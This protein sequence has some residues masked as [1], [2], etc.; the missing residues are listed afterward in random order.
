M[1]REDR[2][3]IPRTVRIAAVLFLAYGAW[4]VWRAAAVQIATHWVDGGDFPRAVIRLAGMSLVSYGLL[5]Q[6]RW[7]W[8]LGL[9]M[10]LLFLLTVVAGIAIA[11]KF[12]AQTSLVGIAGSLTD[13]AVGLG[14]VVTAVV[15]LLLPQTRAYFRPQ[16]N[17]QPPG[18]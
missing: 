16:T 2:T 12:S 5:R 8:W 6:R 13:V 10:P 17:G 15:F 11:L 1:Q 3:P 14:L 4:V 7:A 18:P 9:L